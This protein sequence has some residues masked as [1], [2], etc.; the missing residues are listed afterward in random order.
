MRTVRIHCARALELDAIV[1]LDANGMSHVKVLRLKVGDPLIVFNGRGGEFKA[2]LHEISRQ[3][4]SV[5]VIDYVEREVESSLKIHLGQVISRG[6]KMDFTIQK[7]VELGV[8]EITPLFSERCGV[9]LDKARSQK[10]LDHWQGIIISACEQSGRN[11]LPTLYEPRSL[12]SWLVEQQGLRLALS[13]HADYSIADLRK[14]NERLKKVTLLIGPEG[15]F[16]PTEIA[17][18][19]QQG[20]IEVRLGPRVLR[21]EAAA[22]V[23]LAVLQSC[24]GDLAS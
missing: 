2:K 16:N 11:T 3:Q 19:N 6:D 20:F 10:K 21:T 7:A 22:L 12:E 23:T 9:K 18:A 14:K 24:W 15:G 8:T 17:L 5:Y 4:I 13:P 1:P